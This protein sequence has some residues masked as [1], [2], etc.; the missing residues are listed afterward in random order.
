MEIHKRTPG[1]IRA[2]KV[3]SHLNSTQALRI[4]MNLQDWWGNRAADKLAD[5]GAKIHQPVK[6]LVER[7][8]YRRKMMYKVHQ[9]MV[10][11]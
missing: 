6:E 11:V 2:R 8:K 4:G 7:M 9:F 3:Y 10:H 5:D 1:D